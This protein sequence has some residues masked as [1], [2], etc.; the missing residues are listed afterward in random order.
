[1]CW[2]R[3]QR[4]DEKTADF[5]EVKARLAR[6]LNLPDEQFTVETVIQGMREDICRDRRGHP[7]SADD[8]G[9]PH[10]CHPCRDQRN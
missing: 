3:R 6:R 4:A 10:R 1:M 2:E 7:T 5:I 8:Q 9:A